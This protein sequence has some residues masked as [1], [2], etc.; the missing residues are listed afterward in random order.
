[1]DN[2]AKPDNG[3]VRHLIDAYLD[4]ELSLER[5]LEV[6][7]HL[8][9]CALCRADHESR[10]A[11][12]NAVKAGARR[13]AAPDSLRQAVLAGIKGSPAAPAPARAVRT[14]RPVLRGLA[15]AASLLIAV[16]L[17][18][19]VTSWML[20]PDA[21]DVVAQE[22][23]SSYVRS[24]LVKDRLIDVASSDEHTVKPWLNRQLD[25][26]PPVHD[27]TE[28]GFPLLGGRLDYVASRNVAVLVY[29]HRQHIIN[30][31]IWPA[32][33]GDVAAP[34]KA[35]TR[36]GHNILYWHQD[37]MS[38]WAISDLN[39]AD[40]AAF[41]KLVREAAARGAMGRE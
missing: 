3:H 31:M 15:L 36:Q 18:A 11:V 35:A 30:L 17:G 22:V 4:G 27:F 39:T 26:S 10:R 6:E 9:Q 33:D 21:D 14:R 23:E 40:I 32:R 25:F 13:F 34:E 16:G 28:Q 7:T 12:S 19:G 5:S 1:L 20:H 24:L 2:A 29:R 38:Y 8:G 37:G 41:A